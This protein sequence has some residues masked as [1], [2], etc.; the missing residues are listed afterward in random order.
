MAYLVTD[1]VIG[2]QAIADTSTVQR[3]AFGTIVR[4]KDPDRGEGEFIY[5]KGVSGT[6]VGSWV[7]YNSDD[8]TTTLTVANAIGPVAVAMSINDATTDYG[9]YQISGKASGLSK[10]ISDNAKVWLTASA[11]KVDDTSVAGDMVNICTAASTMSSSL[12]D[13]EIH[14]PFV[15]DRTS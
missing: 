7:T 8:W 13:F 3:H 6:V 10:T 14:R 9:W 12:A 2:H 1:Q 15:N 5:L 11:G 4:A